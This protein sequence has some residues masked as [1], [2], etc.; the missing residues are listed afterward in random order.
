MAVLGGRRATM[1]RAAAL[2]ASLGIVAACGGSAASSAA[3]NGFAN[4]AAGAAASAAPSSQGGN[5]A[6]SGNRFAGDGNGK[7]PSALLDAQKIV[8]TGSLDLVVPDVTQAVDKA[9]AVV[10]GLGGYVGGSHER[11]DDDNPIAQVTYRIPAIRWEDAKASLRALAS[12]VV[13]EETAATEVSGQIVDI[14]ARIKNLRA[15]ETSL[16]GIASG[17]GRVQ[18]LLDVQRELTSVRGQIEELDA[19]RVHLENQA[20]YGTLATTFGVEA[21]AVK[22]AAES[23]NPGGELDRAAGTLVGILETL[24]VAGIWLGVVWLPVILAIAALTVVTIVV[25]RRFGLLRRRDADPPLQ[26]GT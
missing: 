13:S 8:Y 7:P 15:S 5:A 20:S 25:L 11:D 16:Q 14:E 12:K 19:E 18:D 6:P 21:A 26:A 10:I 2:V 4:S 23:W 24:A 22:E 17:T 3:T 9:R 1:L